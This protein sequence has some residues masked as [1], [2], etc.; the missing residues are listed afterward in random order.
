MSRRIEDAKIDVA[1]TLDELSE[2]MNTVA[3]TMIFIAGFSPEWQERAEQL[4]AYATKV[5][6]WA[7][8]IEA[9]KAP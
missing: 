1:L 8:N 7:D 9:G 4:I 3:S 6:Q 2:E 5:K